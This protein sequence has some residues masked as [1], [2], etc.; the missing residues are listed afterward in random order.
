MKSF[1]EKIRDK[2][3]SDL[4]KLLF[5]KI[6]DRCFDFKYNIETSSHVHLENLDFND[7]QKKHSYWYEGTYVVQLRK[8]FNKLQI[9]KEKVFVDIGSGKGRVLLIAAEYGFKKIK[10]VELSPNLCE[11]AKKNVSVFMHK[12]KYNSDVE[13]INKNALHYNFMDDEDILFLYNPFGEHVLEQ[14]LV[15]IKNS[16][17]RNKRS[18]KIIYV[19]PVHGNTIKENIAVVKTTNLRLYATDILIFDV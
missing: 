9:P 18:I 10:G 16:I 15:N 8:L 4:S 6:W 17:E 2:S 11:I 14:L 1:I 3:I 13:V 7:E 19:N 12:K 5:A